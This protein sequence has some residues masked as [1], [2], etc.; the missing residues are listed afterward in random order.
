MCRGVGRRAKLE[1][2]F[3]IEPHGDLGLSGLERGIDVDGA[4]R[5]THQPI[6]LFRQ[7]RERRQVVPPNVEIHRILPGTL[8]PGNFRQ[9]V[10]QTGDIL[11]LGAKT[12]RRKLR[13]IRA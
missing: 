1:S 11:Q 2:P 12:E 3:S 6:G 10:F 7:P 9:H 13:A 8:E 5:V 4:G